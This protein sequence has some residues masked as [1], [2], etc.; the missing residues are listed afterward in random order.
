MSLKPSTPAPEGRRLLRLKEVR[1]R[2]GLQRS[3]I[4]L[5]IKHGEFPAPVHLGA[6]AVAWPSDAID[7][8][9]D[10]RIGIVASQPVRRSP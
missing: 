1:H 6:R 7:A 10:S 2:V 5:K 8:W 9:I 4:Y 3:A